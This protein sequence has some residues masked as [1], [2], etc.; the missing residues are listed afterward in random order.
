MRLL[1]FR[2]N[3]KW[4]FIFFDFQIFD[5]F[6]GQGTDD[7][8][9]DYDDKNPEHTPTICRRIF[10]SIR[11]FQSKTSP[12]SSSD[13][14]FF[15]GNRY[16]RTS[17]TDPCP[18]TG[19]HP[20]RFCPKV[21]SWTIPTNLYGYTQMWTNTC[22]VRSLFHFFA[23]ETGIFCKNL[24]FYEEEEQSKKI[25]KNQLTNCRRISRSNKKWWKSYCTAEFCGHGHRC[26]QSANC[27]R[28]CPC[29]WTQAQTYSWN[30]R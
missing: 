13:V 21:V 29:P 1:S 4:K 22:S 11:S 24:L 7:G 30:R 23:T 14:Q 26:L 16:L 19:P 15:C 17:P 18:Q 20:R 5:F 27:R 3:Q 8:S 28:L 12:S 6:R 9:T 2:S 25:L 10:F